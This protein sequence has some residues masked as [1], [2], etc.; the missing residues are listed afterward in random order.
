M[1]IVVVTHELASVAM[2]A[3]RVALL[4]SGK[5]IA[6][7]TIAELRNSGNEK[8]EQFFNRIPDPENI[9]KQSYLNSLIDN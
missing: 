6:L 2:I 3:D 9:D 4:D 7:G 5:I 8:V 1:T